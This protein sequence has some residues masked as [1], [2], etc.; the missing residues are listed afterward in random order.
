[1]KQSEYNFFFKTEQNE[2]LAFNALKNGLAVINEELVNEIKNLREGNVPKLEE[3][4]IKEL[5]KG[6]FICDDSM[7][8]Y[9]LISVRRH[10]QQYSSN[11]FGLTIAPTINCNLAC[12]YCFES[13]SP[14]KMNDEVI[15]NVAKMVKSRIDSGIKEF[16]VTWYGGEPLLCL[17]VIEKLSKKFITLC[18]ENEINYSAYIITNGTLYTPEVAEKLKNLKVTGAQITIDGDRAAHDKRRPYRGGG[19]SF[20]KIIKNFKDSAGILPIGLRVNVD[21]DNV[22]HTLDFFESLRSDKELEEHF[23]SNRI[24]VHYGYVRKLSSSCGCSD[25]ECLLPGEFWQNELKLHQ[26]LYKKG[27]GFNHYPDIM[28]GC[29]ATTIHGYVVGPHGELYKCWNHVGEPERI[30]GNVAETIQL[31][32]LYV[33]YLSESFEKDEECKKCKYLPICMGGCVDIRVKHQK[34]EFPNID[35]SRWKYYLEE[36]LKT[37]Y[38]ASLGNNK[39]SHCDKNCGC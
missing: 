11:S 18:E 14:D 37:Y 34:G 19:G 20:D 17:D 26:H 7:D 27:H 13:P 21:I 2:Y 28:S 5:K 3:E 33:S 35:C 39:K 1:M 10:I 32:S 36:S 29:V 23:K 15:R 6:G 24:R 9:G 12:T 31:D 4:T 25:E 38:L 16:N 8:E 22:D 30:V